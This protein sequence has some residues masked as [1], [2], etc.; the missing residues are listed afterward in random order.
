MYESTERRASNP[1]SS[2]T[3]YTATMIKMPIRICPARVPLTIIS[4]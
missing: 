4:A 3:T 2:A 1:A